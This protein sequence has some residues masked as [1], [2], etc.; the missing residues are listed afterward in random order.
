M[1]NEKKEFPKKILMS[2]IDAEKG[3]YAV[4]WR[5]ESKQPARIEGATEDWVTYTMIAGTDKGTR[6][7][8]K[9]DGS[10]EVDVYDKNTA[11]L[12]ALDT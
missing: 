12:A 10:Q 8:G 1:P 3:N 5:G 4:F 2:D 7:R 9:Y 6:Y 11:I